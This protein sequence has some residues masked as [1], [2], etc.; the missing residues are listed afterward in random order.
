MKGLPFSG[1]M[2]TMIGLG[3]KTSGVAEQL[4]MVN[5]YFEKDVKRTTKKVLTMMEPI[6]LVVFGGISAV[7]L[8]STFF[9]MYNAMGT[10]K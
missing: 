9:P 3:E 5:T 4:A 1:F 10:M 6:I 2:V 8:L 7:I